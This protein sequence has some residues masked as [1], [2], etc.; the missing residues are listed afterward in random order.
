[1]FSETRIECVSVGAK[2]HYVAAQYLKEI[3]QLFY[4]IYLH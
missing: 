4:L 1:M 2:K 3:L